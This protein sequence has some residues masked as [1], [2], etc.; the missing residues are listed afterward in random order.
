MQCSWY[1]GGQYIEHTR[2]EVLTV[3]KTRTAVF[4]RPFIVTTKDSEE[5]VVPVWINQDGVSRRKEQNNDIA[6]D[7]ERTSHTACH[8]HG[9]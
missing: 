7:T 1:P 9:P 4:L 3:M 5:R 8:C 6:K 2:Y